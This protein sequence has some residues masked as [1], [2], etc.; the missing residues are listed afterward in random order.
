MTHVNIGSNL[1]LT[2]MVDTGPLIP[3]Y[4]LWYKGDQ[5]I[6][7]SEDIK[8]KVFTTMAANGTGRPHQSEMLIRNVSARDSGVY[9]CNSDLTDEAKI[10]VY[11][12]E[13]DLKS[14]HSETAAAAASGNKQSTSKDTPSAAVASTANSFGK[15][16]KTGSLLDFF[17]FFPLSFLLLPV[18][19]GCWVLLLP[20]RL[21]LVL[22]LLC[23]G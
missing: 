4:I 23:M 8:A 9:R 22:T 3:Q 12:V 2:C 5:I 7:Y 10:T 20:K 15:L 11:V 13:E 17:F 21:D 19:M 14:L 6:A 16:E 1:V 18:S